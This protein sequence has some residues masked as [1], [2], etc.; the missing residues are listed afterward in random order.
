MGVAAA[1]GMEFR[2]ERQH[3]SNSDKG[4]V[5]TWLRTLAP[6]PGCRRMRRLSPAAATRAP[7]AIWVRAWISNRV[8]AFPQ[9]HVGRLGPDAPIACDHVPDPRARTVGPGT[10]RMPA[11]GRRTPGPAV[12]NSD[13][14]WTLRG[15]GGH[16]E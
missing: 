4:F 1:P 2:R 6:A 7:L 11:Q 5:R 16:A 14:V 13:D 3:A 15:G 8:S 10:R 12:P 9:C